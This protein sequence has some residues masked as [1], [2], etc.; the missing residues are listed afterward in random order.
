MSNDKIF[1]GSDP[2][3]LVLVLEVINETPAGINSLTPGH[4]S[5]IN[6]LISV[7]IIR[8][9]KYSMTIPLL[10]EL[11]DFPEHRLFV[12]G[13]LQP[14]RE[15]HHLLSGLTGQWLKGYITGEL[16]DNGWGAGMGYPSLVWNLH[17]EKINGHLLISKELVDNWE[18]LDEFEGSDYKR[19]LVPV[20]CDS[21]I[22]IANVYA[23]S[24]L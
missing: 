22:Q 17:G 1:P 15:N 11:L 2:A 20:F 8:E 10:N 3:L 7:N 18:R 19:I 5:K 23:S 14:G 6:D 13:S 4:I 21:R 16:S 24:G 12:Y 9:K